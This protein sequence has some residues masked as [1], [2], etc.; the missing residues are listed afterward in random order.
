MPSN[1]KRKQNHPGN[2]S[3]KSS[4][5]AVVSLTVHFALI[6]ALIACYDIL[7][8]YFAAII[9]SLSAI[10]ILATLVIQIK[11]WK[12]DKYMLNLFPLLGYI[13]LFLYSLTLILD[14][15]PKQKIT[16]L[17]YFYVGPFALW[18]TAII[19]IFVSFLMLALWTW[20]FIKVRSFL[21]TYISFL[22]L[23]IG[24]SSFGALLFA[25]LAF[26]SVKQNHLYVVTKAAETQ[27]LL[28]MQSLNNTKKAATAVANESAIQQALLSD[29]PDK[30]TRILSA[31]SKEETRKM[32]INVYNSSSK[33][34]HRYSLSKNNIGIQLQNAFIDK[35]IN[36]DLTLKALDSTLVNLKTVLEAR[37]ATPVKNNGEIIGALETVYTFDNEFA[38]YVKM[39]TGVDVTLFASDEIL[40]TTLQGIVKDEYSDRRIEVAEIKTTVLSAQQK[41]S[42]LVSHN[43]KTYYAA[44][45]PI[46]ND[47]GEVIGVLE[48]SIP[49]ERLLEQT[50]QQLLTTF[51][52]LVLIFSLVAL[53]GYYV[54][55]IFYENKTK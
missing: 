44:Y 53:L 6:I 36:E 34:I 28:L 49:S 54:L 16:S 40:A 41:Y 18:Q 14:Q 38:N 9:T 45:E 43:G 55:Y 39:K 30:L 12:Y 47:S 24:I 10:F 35:V 33:L 42:N 31:F 17:N 7:S 13:L 23:M 50:R 25:I 37:S 48:A 5:L 52:T 46:T 8:D 32:D 26:N 21:K 15:L 51:I 1:K 22:A 19:L 27:K 20:Q 2:K 4:L 3:N 29:E 11:R